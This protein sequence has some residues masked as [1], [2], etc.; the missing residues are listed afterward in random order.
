MLGRL[1]RAS[2][3]RTWYRSVFSQIIQIDDG[4][5]ARLEAALASA[6]VAEDRRHSIPDEAALIYLAA[7]FASI[8]KLPRANEIGGTAARREL[9]MLVELSYKLRRHILS[10]HR[11]ALGAI[12]SEPGQARPPLLIVDDLRELIAVAARARDVIEPTPTRRG[13]RPDKQAVATTKFVANVFER[14]TGRQAAPGYDAYDERRSA[15]ES[16]LGDVFDALGID[17]NAERQ[18]KLLA[19]D[20]KAK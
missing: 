20:K 12:E 16:L 4:L 10:M 1:L 2:R 6:P 19:R 14:L 17:A 5:R 7:S 18:A 9:D 8:N 13:R 3:L 11:E 15:F